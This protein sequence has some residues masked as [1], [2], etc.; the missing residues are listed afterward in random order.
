[1]KLLLFTLT[2]ILYSSFNSLKND[3]EYKFHFISKLI[4]QQDYNEA[5]RE[6]E[7]L[8]ESNSE[9][10]IGYILKSATLLTKSIDFEDELNFYEIKGLLDKAK[11]LIR[12]KQSNLDIY[13]YDVYEG[14]INSISAF[15]HYRNGDLIYAFIKGYQAVRS[16]D[17][18]LRTNPNSA[19]ALLAIGIFKYWKSRKSELIHWLPFVEDEREEG[20]KLIKKGLMSKSPFR[21]LGAYSLA[22]IYIDNNQFNEAIKI[23]NQYL[24]QNPN[25]RFFNWALARAY[26][27]ID[28]EKSITQYGR[29]LQLVKSEKM[30]GYNEVVLLHII[31]QQYFKLGNY[32]MASYY[33]EKIDEVF[34][35]IYARKRLDDRFDRINNMKFQIKQLLQN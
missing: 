16:F 18:E 20:I 7:K 35:D 24:E 14:L 33:L 22:W 13:S 3:L 12:L 8:I 30:N 19:E 31:A 25:S 34:I 28:I 23:C 5:I 1:M 6:A 21:F 9:K 11:D 2:F 15:V 10:P 4:F 26:E 17:R 29:T 32:K 27:G